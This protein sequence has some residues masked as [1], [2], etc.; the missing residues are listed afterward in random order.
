MIGFER[1]SLHLYWTDIGDEGGLAYERCWQVLSPSEKARAERF[2]FDIHRN[3]FVRANGQLRAILSGYLGIPAGE[4]E[5][6]AAARGKPFIEGAGIR[7]N[8]SHSSDIAV[9]AVSMEEVGVDVEL[10]DRDVEIEDLAR[11]YY[12]EAEQEVLL[13]LADER[14]KQ[15][16][17]FWLWTA[18]EARMKVTGEGLA[19]DPRRIDVRIVAGRPHAYHKP[20]TPATSLLPVEINGLGGAC[21]VAGLSVPPVLE[22]RALGD[23]M[24]R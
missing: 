13:N 7:F 10:F 3:R 9:Y 14:E 2:H 20:E 11:H 24:M 17:F 21:C 8:M 15:E 5:L 1:N 12:T 6:S 22:I 4:I 16:L 19:L 18:K 23:L